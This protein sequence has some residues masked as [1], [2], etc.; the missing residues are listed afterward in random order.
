MLLDTALPPNFRAFLMKELEDREALVL[1]M[2][3]LLRANGYI[4]Q[5]ELY[6]HTLAMSANPVPI[7]HMS[8]ETAKQLQATSIVLSSS[9]GSPIMNSPIW[10]RPPLPMTGARSST[11]G[12]GMAGPLVGHPVS[13]HTPAAATPQADQL[14]EEEDRKRQQLHDLPD[15]DEQPRA[16]SASHSSAPDMEIPVP[17]RIRISS[18]PLPPMQVNPRTN[19]GTTFEPRSRPQPTKSKYNVVP[20]AKDV[21]LR[22]NTRDMWPTTKQF[23]QHKA[24]GTMRMMDEIVGGAPITGLEKAYSMPSDE[25]LRRVCM[26]ASTSLSVLEARGISREQFLD[27]A[28]RHEEGNKMDVADIMKQFYNPTSERE[29]LSDEVSDEVSDDGM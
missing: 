9:S 11:M 24:T 18:S 2:E 6:Q 28:G 10:F 25:I 17:K 1:R 21:V 13:Y 23:Y 7:Q 22:D 8:D 5:D 16:T 29:D 19:P 20:P 15:S 27:I 26:L 3:A 14:L 12:S 4:R